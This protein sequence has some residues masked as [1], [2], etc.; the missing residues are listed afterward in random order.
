MDNAVPKTAADT[1]FT[2]QM[3]ETEPGPRF[4]DLL[5]R[6]SDLPVPYPVN[7]LFCAHRP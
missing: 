5:R 3:E 7:T 2:S 6:G 1:N 4:A